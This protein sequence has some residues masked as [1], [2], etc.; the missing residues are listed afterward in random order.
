M[1]DRVPLAEAMSELIAGRVAWHPPWFQ[2]GA[3]MEAW[4]VPESTGALL[5]VWDP[6]RERAER[7][8]TYDHARLQKELPRLVTSGVV[9]TR[10]IVPIASVPSAVAACGHALL[11]RLAATLRALRE[12]PTLCLARPLNPDA[13]DLLSHRSEV[14]W[15]TCVVSKGA[16]IR[17]GRH[18][19]DA[20]ESVISA[21]LFASDALAPT[22]ID[23]AVIAHLE[24]A[25]GRWIAL[26]ERMRRGEIGWRVH[27]DR[28]VVD[29]D[30]DL[31]NAA[32]HGTQVTYS[33]AFARGHVDSDM[34][35][36][37]L[38]EAEPSAIVPL[39]PGQQASLRASVQPR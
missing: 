18:D 24:E 17:V 5:V 10:D 31:F 36:R 1:T 25:E 37:T 6:S 7:A 22:P 29:V 12:D 16:P 19:D 9:W 23:P 34:L 21:M 4:L 20:I 26:R 14:G 30:G 35:T 8:V 2:P 15:R 13:T 3:P 38:T 27:V 28:V 11:A 32:F 33:H 39:L